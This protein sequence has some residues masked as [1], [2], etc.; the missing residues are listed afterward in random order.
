MQNFLN[1]EKWRKA[2]WTFGFN[3]GLLKNV[4]SLIKL[5]IYKKKLDFL[6]KIKSSWCF[7]HF[8]KFKYFL[9]NDSLKPNMIWK[10]WTQECVKLKY[11]SN[12]YKN[13]TFCVWENLM[14]WVCNGQINSEWEI[15]VKITYKSSFLLPLFNGGLELSLSSKCIVK[16]LYPKRKQVISLRVN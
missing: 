9:H 7:C 1:F 10:D 14:T 15:R 8:T 2:C 16:C 12:G 5:Y 11:Y 4:T 6:H 13:H 3:F